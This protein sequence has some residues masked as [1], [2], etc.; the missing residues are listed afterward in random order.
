MHVNT[1]S[2]LHI[3]QYE[4]SNNKLSIHTSHQYIQVINSNKSYK[5][6]SQIHKAWTHDISCKSLTVT[7]TKKIKYLFKEFKILKGSMNTY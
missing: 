7:H 2:N 1:L 3:S 5:Y 6:N 4:L